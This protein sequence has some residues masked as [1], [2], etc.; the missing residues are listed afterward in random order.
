MRRI[1]WGLLAAA[2]VAIPVAWAASTFS[3]FPSA[4]QPLGGLPDYVPM[5][6]GTGCTTNPPTSCTTVQ[7]PSTRIGQAVQA[8]SGCPAF[9]SGLPSPFNTPFKYQPCWDTSI[10]PAAYRYWDGSQWVTV[11]NF[12]TTNHLWVPPIGG[13]TLPTIAGQ[14]ITDLCAGTPQS[15]VYVS[16]A[17]N[18]TSFGSTCPQGI[19][20]VVIWQ[21]TPTVIYN[22]SSMILPGAM[23]ITVTP[24]EAWYLLSLGGGNWQLLFG[25]PGGTFTGVTS[26][27][28]RTGAV[29]PAA[30]DYN[31]NQIYGVAAPAQV[32]TEGA[33]GSGTNVAAS[34]AI[35]NTSVQLTADSFVVGTALNSGAT[36][37]LGSVNQ[38]FNSATTGA[39]G[40]DVSP[41]PTSGFVC[42]YVI[43]GSSGTSTLGRNCT[44]SGGTT[45]YGGSH[46]PNG[47]TFSALFATWPTNSTP[48]MIA[49][50]VRG[51]QLSFA[52]I[53]V[54]NGTSSEASWTGQS[55]STAVPPNAISVSGTAECS[56]SGT[57]GGNQWVLLASDA[58]G[59]GEQDIYMGGNGLTSQT[60]SGI[61]ASLLMPSA[62][63]IFYQ[64]ESRAGGSCNIYAS[65]YAIP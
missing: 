7:T 6:Q 22:A 30:G 61:F 8:A 51:K 38:T 64:Y 55:I 62:Q 59:I 29:T 15:T 5:D 23:N 39:G 48:A 19:H 57:A 49:G 28:G 26:F 24:G 2:V 37:S 50:Y 18:I 52:A 21:S 20:K 11:A 25:E 46:M 47:Y 60:N 43:Y 54:F 13:G 44:S 12:D 9:F 27:N 35:A 56:F 32:P 65:S 1:W 42:I 58:N 41:L 17:P 36:L 14:P 3:G 63:N 40:M 53:N 31:F 34:L 16:G 4:T 10:S 45:I 33:I